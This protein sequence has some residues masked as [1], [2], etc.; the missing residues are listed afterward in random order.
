MMQIVDSD[1][2]L[3]RSRLSKT[4]THRSYG[5]N[6]HRIHADYLCAQG[7]SSLPLPIDFRLAVLPRPRRFNALPALLVYTHTNSFARSAFVSAIRFHDMRTNKQ[8]QRARVYLQI[9]TSEH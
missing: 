9:A 5:R 6:A 8:K 1:M 7:C 3:R 4:D 2:Q